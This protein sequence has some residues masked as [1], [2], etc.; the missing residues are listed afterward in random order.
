MLLRDA[1]EE[2]RILYAAKRTAP[3]AQRDPLLTH[4]SE[5]LDVLNAVVRTPAD[6]LQALQDPKRAVGMLLLVGFALAN[7][8]QVDSLDAMKSILLE[9]SP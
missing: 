7:D 2:T 4:T 3:G 1:Q 6:R 5:A 9:Q 8:L